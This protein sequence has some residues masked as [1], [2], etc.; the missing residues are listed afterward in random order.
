MGSWFQGDESPSPSLQAVVMLG[1]AAESQTDPFS[2]TLIKGQR[3]LQL[4][5][6]Q[7]LGKA[8]LRL[9]PVPQRS[10]DFWSWELGSSHPGRNRNYQSQGPLCTPSVMRLRYI[11]FP[12]CNK[13]HC[14]PFVKRFLISLLMVLSHFTI[15]A[16]N[17]VPFLPWKSPCVR[18]WGNWGHNFKESRK[19]RPLAFSLPS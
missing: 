16:A 8:S 2:E 10:S 15:D 4:C 17:S 3:E 5:P 13:I 7:E 12:L 14:V 19:S 11:V 1:A 18:S 6:I 9:E